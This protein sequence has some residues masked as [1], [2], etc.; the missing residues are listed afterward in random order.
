MEPRTPKALHKDR[1][2]NRLGD[3]IEQMLGVQATDLRAEELFQ[4]I[5][6]TKNTETL[7]SSERPK[8]IS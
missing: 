1:T 2:F 3:P 6:P 7:P 5:N 4:A 8:T